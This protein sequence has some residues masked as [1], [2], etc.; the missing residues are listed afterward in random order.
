MNL[1]VWSSVSSRDARDQGPIIIESPA[2]EQGDPS[3]KS[4]RARHK[5]E[6]RQGGRRQ[7][8]GVPATAL[9][10]VSGCVAA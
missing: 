3:G 9:R 10:S 1:P 7:G 6:R 8:G 4:A 2:D 5:E